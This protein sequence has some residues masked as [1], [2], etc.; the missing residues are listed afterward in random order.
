MKMLMGEIFPSQAPLDG[1]KISRTLMKIPG[2]T[3]VILAIPQPTAKVT[4]IHPTKFLKRVMV[5]VRPSPVL[6]PELTIPVVLETEVT[7]G[8]DWT[9]YRIRVLGGRETVSLAVT[10]ALLA[11]AQLDQL[12]VLLG[13]VKI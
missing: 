3:Q 6:L 2:A 4:S 13:P 7:P 9:D 11:D 8:T 10:Q 1:R 5:P 12:A